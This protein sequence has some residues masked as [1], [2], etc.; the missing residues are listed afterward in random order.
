MKHNP[1]LITGYKSPEYFCDREIESGTLRNAIENH[2]NI[3]LISS[4]RMGKT[5][6][7]QHVFSDMSKKSGRIP[8][9]FDIMGTTGF[10]EF[11]EV[12]CNAVLRSMSKT[13]R[14][15]K[16]FLR[17]LGS[18]R[19]ALAFDSLTGEPRISLD[20]RSA[21]EIDLSL[22]MIFRLMGEKKQ[23]FVIAIDEF[24]QIASYP[25]KNVEA[26]LRSHVQKQS[27]VCFIFSGS[28]KH[29]LSAMFSKPSRPFF[30]STQMM[31]LEHIDRE[32]YFDFIRSHFAGRGKQIE[33]EALE[34]IAEYTQLHT[35]YVQFLCNRL[36]GTFKNVGIKEVDKVLYTILRENE[37][38]YAS[39][40]NLLTIS[41]YR[42]L[43]AIALEGMVEKP[44]SG[45]FLAAHHLGAASSVSQAVSSLTK[46]ELIHNDSGRLSVQDKFFAQWI[47]TK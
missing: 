28:K 1:F 9:Y 47:R 5:G 13:E 46:K 27:N 3:T 22:D 23:Y 11:A 7:I 14:A 10:N 16:G 21:E 20:I 19:P 32:A 25:E 29:M 24:Q 40:L 37:P 42:T 4:R 35:F 36:F 41:Q 31:F 15:W 33:N 34:R 12:L 6:L 45:N 38:I 8:V 43:R 2:R 44:T 17:K 30:N 39:Y 26:I 18:L